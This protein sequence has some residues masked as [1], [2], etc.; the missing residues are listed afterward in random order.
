MGNANQDNLW[1]QLTIQGHQDRALDQ[2]LT[3]K[4]IMDSWTLQK[5]YPVISLQRVVNPV[6]N[7]LTLKLNQ[8]WFLLNPLSK[9]LKTEEY[10]K[11]RW[12]VPFTYTTQTNPR[13]SFESKTYWMK[14]E[15][16]N[17]EINIPI[18]TVSGGGSN[19]A[20]VWVLGN[21]EFSG[22]YR[23]NYDI[24]SWGLLINQLKA[25]HEKIGTVNRAQLIDDSFNLAKAEFIPNSIYLD[26]LSYLTNET[27][28]LPF[29]AAKDGLSYM[30]EMFSANYVVSNSFK[31]CLLKKSLKKNK[32]C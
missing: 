20:S 7:S 12:Y 11:K 25:D 15:S 8:A 31:V 10:D 9:L 30:E 13:F 28:S 2:D 17:D 29:K 27:D 3:I 24:V 23:V 26:L 32:K 4:Q 1:E 18:E 16:D 6:N 14:P 5:G 21:V 22:F 19:L